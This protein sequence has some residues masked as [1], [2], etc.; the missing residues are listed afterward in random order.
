MKN[1]IYIATSLDGYIAETNGNIDWLHAIPNPTGSDFGFTTFMEQVDAL[2]MGKNTFETVCNFE[3]PWPY[4][5][6]VYVLSNS[7]K[8]IPA[9]L[10]DKS[11]LIKG[12]PK[13]VLSQL[14]S[15]G[16]HKVYIDGGVT[17]QSFLKEDLI[18]EMIIS[19]IPVI[20]GSGIPLFSKLDKKLWFEH[21]STEVLLNQ[22]VKSHYKRK[23]D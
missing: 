22:L 15:K 14:K 17:I 7:L 9:K 2:I 23:R 18:D 1:I 10:K 11:Q 21:I 13:E 12:S 4:S 6:P 19:K 5:K 20:L 16:I 8:E 3:G